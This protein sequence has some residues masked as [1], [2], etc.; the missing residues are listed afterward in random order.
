LQSD[1]KAIAKRLHSDR[2]VIGMYNV[3]DEFHRCNLED[4]KCR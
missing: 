3:N 2:G 4:E 1:C